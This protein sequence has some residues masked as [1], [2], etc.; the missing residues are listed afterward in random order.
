MRNLVILFF[1]ISLISLN[2]CKKDD[3][4]GPKL[5]NDYN[6]TL[7]LEY[8]RSAMN[9]AAIIEIDVSINKEGDFLFSQPDQETFQGEHEF[10]M[11]NSLIRLKETG[12][13]MVS[14][15]TGEITE[16]GGNDYVEIKTVT[17]IYI[18]QKIWVWDEDQGWVLAYENS[19]APDDPVDYPIIFN[20]LEST[21]DFVDVGGT[22][23]DAYGDITYKWS[24]FLLPH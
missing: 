22:I 17:D 6:G 15:P 18:E 7:R 9:F 16:I 21:I 11:E 4:E 5:T 14:Y 3:N 19:Y 12:T 1:I 20:L 2:G 10:I 23:Q 13:M 8:A 24:L